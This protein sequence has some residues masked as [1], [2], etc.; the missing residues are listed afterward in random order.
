[1]VDP[2]IG[3]PDDLS[4]VDDLDAAH[5]V[6][7]LSVRI[8]ADLEIVEPY[9]EAERDRPAG[10]LSTDGVLGFPLAERHGAPVAEHEADKAAE[11]DNKDAPVDHVDAV[12]GEAPLF[13]DRAAPLSGPAGTL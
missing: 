7:R 3:L 12:P 13:E 5:V 6:L 2:H 9:A 11:K 1:M 4:L 10:P 8:E